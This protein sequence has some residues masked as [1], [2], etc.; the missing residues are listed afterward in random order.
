MNAATKAVEALIA[1]PGTA[2]ALTV[3]ER[4]VIALAIPAEK[5]TA[6]KTL[7]QSTKDIVAI[8]NADGRE[9]VYRARITL[10]NERVAIKAAGK[11]AR[12]DATALS[13]AV[14]ALENGLVAIIEPEEERLQKLQDEYDQRAE[15]LKQALIERELERTRLIRERITEMREAVPASIGRSAEAILDRIGEI[16][17]E[18]IDESFG[19]YQVEAE[20]ARL[21]SIAR[22][23]EIHA[24]A[25]AH[26]AEQVR[27]AAER[28]E[29]NRRR[30]ED[31]ER[32]RKAAEERAH[33]DKLLRD[34]TAIAEQPQKL[35]GASRAQ[36]LQALENAKLWPVNAAIFGALVAVAQAAKAASITAIEGAL[37]THDRRIEDE[38]REAAERTRQAQERER[39]AKQQRDADEL[40]RREQAERDRQA[41]AQRRAD[42]EAARKQ[43]EAERI[44]LAR[45]NPPT[46][47]DILV[48]VATEHLVPTHVALE[49]IRN[50]NWQ[51]VP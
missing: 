28:V 11:T 35:R 47:H 27:I 43:A 46:A 6:L 36:I 51:E 30:A 10:K 31:A 42:A 5:E 34:I 20:D 40:A 32:D 25:V 29:L 23:R 1:S 33:T 9:Q 14:I 8:T 12:E 4:A 7:A 49:W 21:A 45:G 18:V 41:E 50:I 48:L 39:L 19:E 17:R 2:V 24:A 22:L 16:E 44:E 37:V 13:K 38:Q 15:A 3:K 26:E